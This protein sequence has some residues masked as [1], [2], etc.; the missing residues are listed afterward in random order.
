MIK[1]TNIIVTASIQ[2][3]DKGALFKKEI[4]DLGLSEEDVKLAEIS[5]KAN[6]V[7]NFIVVHPTVTGS[8]DVAE[9]YFTPLYKETINYDEWKQVIN[10]KFLELEA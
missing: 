2:N 6:Y 4:V 9:L 3:P 7:S 1:S 10:K 5:V 8:T